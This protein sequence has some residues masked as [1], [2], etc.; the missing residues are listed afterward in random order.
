MGSSLLVT[1]DASVAS[2]PEPGAPVT[3]TVGVTNLSPVDTVT[4]S[5]ITNSVSGGTPFPAGGTC[6]D[7]EADLAP[8]A[9]ASCAFTFDVAGDA[10][11]TITDTVTVVADDG[12]PEPVPGAPPRRRPAAASAATPIRCPHPIRRRPKR[13]QPR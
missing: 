9:S 10:G 8:G 1:K 2:V 5:S 7:L 11:D 3:F 13:A 6:P 12:D 4:I